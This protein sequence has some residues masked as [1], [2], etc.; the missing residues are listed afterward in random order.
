M[1]QSHR[2]PVIAAI[3]LCLVTA[4]SV[5][6]YQM[7][8]SDSPITIDTEP[9]QNTP[10]PQIA[11]PE[12]DP[13]FADNLDSSEPEQAPLDDYPKAKGDSPKDVKAASKAKGANGLE[14]IS[15]GENTNLFVTEKGQIWY[16]DKGADGKVT[17]MQVMFDEVTG[18]MTVVENGDNGK[19]DGSRGMQTISMGDQENLYITHEGTAWYV[20]EGPDGETTKTQ[21]IIDETTG[22]MIDDEDDYSE[23]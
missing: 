1:K 5:G 12:P 9:D 15:L 4:V 21:V 17:K 22:E 23:K 13:Q 20:I 14:K 2:L 11:I 18:V 10:A 3:V 19:Y 16:V 6:I 8:S 7:Q